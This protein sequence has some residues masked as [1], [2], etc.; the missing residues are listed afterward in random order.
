[1]LMKNQHPFALHSQTMLRMDPDFR[2]DDAKIMDIIVFHRVAEA[3]FFGQQRSHRRQQ[4]SVG[5]AS[6][7]LRPATGCSPARISGETPSGAA[8]LWHIRQLRR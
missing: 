7:G 3:G 5:I 6:R 8:R 2:Q 1:M 4:V